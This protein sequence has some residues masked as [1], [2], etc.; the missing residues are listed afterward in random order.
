[1]TLHSCDTAK[2]DPTTVVNG[3][4]YIKKRHARSLFLCPMKAI[5]RC[6]DLWD[7]CVGSPEF[8][9]DVISDYLILCVQ[10]KL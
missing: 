5:E 7:M 3:Y 9:V 8:N 1:M 10:K 6:T 2:S 4:I